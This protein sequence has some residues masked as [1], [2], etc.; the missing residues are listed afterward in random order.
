[1]TQMK[2]SPFLDTFNF[3]AAD[4]LYGNRYRDG[5]KITLQTLWQSQALKRS[6]DQIKAAQAQQSTSLLS[7]CG[8]YLV[9][10]QIS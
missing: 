9:M 1:M 4:E 6:N 5:N 3:I 8:I 10:C 7:T 2:I